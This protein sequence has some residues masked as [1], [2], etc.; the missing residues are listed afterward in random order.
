MKESAWLL[1][2]PF[3]LATH[4]AAGAS[5]PADMDQAF[6]H[7]AQLPEKLVPILSSA[8]D[9]ESADAAANAL[10]RT[11]PAIYDAQTELRQFQTLS[12]DVSGAV[13]EK[14]ERR[15]RTG[16]GEVYQHIFRLQK[17]KC[18]GSLPFFRQFQTM[19]R[20]LES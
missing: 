12:P 11:L 14:Y 20:M 10:F 1:F 16:W 6:E 9:K 18:Y 13:R 7:Y 4:L 5:I 8:V 15:I 19:C 2:C 17:D 3:V